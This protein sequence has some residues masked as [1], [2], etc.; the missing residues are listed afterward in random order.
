MDDPSDNP[1]AAPPAD[2]PSDEPN[3]LKDWER[4]ILV[5][6]WLHRDRPVKIGEALASNILSWGRKAVGL[7]L[8]GVG[9]HFVLP[10]ETR[11]DWLTVYAACATGLMWGRI[12]T[13]WR[14]ARH[15]V[16]SW[17]LLHCILDWQ[18]IEAWIDER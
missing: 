14:S 1:Y 17:R 7:A 12:S 13:E 6:Y 10:E 2:R 8:I 15:F 5:F 3:T 11:G 18:K 4:A 9:L 16:E